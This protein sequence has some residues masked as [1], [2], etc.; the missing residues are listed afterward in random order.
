MKTCRMKN[1]FK[2]K[3]NCKLQFSKLITFIVWI[4]MSH[5]FHPCCFF[6]LCQ[7]SLHCLNEPKPKVSITGVWVVCNSGLLMGKC[8]QHNFQIKFYRSV[9]HTAEML[10]EKIISITLTSSCWSSVLPY[11]MIFLKYQGSKL[12]LIN[13]QNVSDFDNLWVRKIS[14]SKMF[15]S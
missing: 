11:S 6:F 4:H 10:K 7:N 1:P 14:T 8:A 15:A 5:S 2:N 12:T 3:G 13:S 9:F